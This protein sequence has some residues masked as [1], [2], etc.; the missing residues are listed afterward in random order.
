MIV[1]DETVRFGQ[2]EITLGIIPGGGG[3][4]RLPRLIGASRAKDL[5][6]TGRQVRADEALAMGLVDEVVEAGRATE[7]ALERAAGLAGGAVAA[8]AL[9]KRAIDE[10][11]DGPLPDGLALE[12]E[13]FVEVFTTEDSRAGVASFLEHGPGK[14]TF[15]GR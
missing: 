15:T 8:Q 7:R 12:Q 1:A 5:I 4:Q 3:T 2:P 11:L 6:L 9:A 10:G 14:A 13:L